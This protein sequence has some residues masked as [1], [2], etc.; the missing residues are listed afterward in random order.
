MVVLTGCAIGHVQLEPMVIR[1]LDLVLE[2]ALHIVVQLMM[3]ISHQVAFATKS[4]HQQPSLLICRKEH[5]F[6]AV[7]LAISRT[8]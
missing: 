8:M 2:L 6:Q 5:A 3:D 7:L 1:N 4:A